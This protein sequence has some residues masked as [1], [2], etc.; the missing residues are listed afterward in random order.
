MSKWYQ[1]INL[2]A[3][4][5]YLAAYHVKIWTLKSASQ[6]YLSEQPSK[7][8]DEINDFDVTALRTIVIKITAN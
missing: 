6:K 3:E 1:K 5:F 2:L 8:G 7:T 4:I